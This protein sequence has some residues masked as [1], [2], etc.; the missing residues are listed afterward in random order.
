LSKPNGELIKKIKSVEGL[1][2]FWKFDEKPGRERK[3]SVMEKYPLQES[4]GI[5]TRINEGPLSGFSILFDGT[6]YL[7][8]DHSQTGKLNIFGDQSEITLVAWIKWTGEQTGFV[9]GIRIS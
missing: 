6:N 8:L 5:V 1:V 2:S 4:N 9:G 7:T 3:S